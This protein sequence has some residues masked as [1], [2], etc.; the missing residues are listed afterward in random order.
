MKLELERPKFLKAWQTA[1]KYIASKTTIGAMNGIRITAA[2]NSITLEATDMKSSV[3][4]TINEANVQEAGTAVLNA[5]VCGDMLRKTSEQS[6]TLEV[7]DDKGTLK[8]GKNRSRFP[9]IPADTFPNLPESSGAE[10]ICEIMASDLGK[11][12]TEGSCAA[13]APSD[14]PKYMGTCLLRTSGQYLTAVSTDGKRLARSQRLCTVHKEG[15]FLIPAPAL[16]EAAKNFNSSDMVKMFADGSTVWFIFDRKV[17]I[18]EETKDESSGDTNAAAVNWKENVV[19]VLE[20]SIQ[21]IDA[22]FPKFER[23]LNNEIRTT[24]KVSKSSLVSAV[25]R[26]DIIAKNTTAHLMAVL[27]NPEEAPKLRITARAPELGT[28]SEVVDASV[29]GQAMQIGFN[30]AYFLDGLKAADAD[31]VVVEFSD[32]EGQARIFRDESED[33]LY[34]LMPIKLTP[35]DIVNDDDSGD[36]AAPVY[37]DDFS[38]ENDSDSQDDYNP[39]DEDTSQYDNSDAPF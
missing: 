1:E 13:S 31:S 27:M 15:D 17:L 37:P 26:V 8:S 23:I 18:K 33:F 36:F 5:A 39:Q 32:E 12:I 6:I 24:L 16:K 29:D 38:Q 7:R 2:D 3:K 20:F 9:L 21:R 14:F 10:E 30:A 34:M 35:Q 19:E 4:F 11:L 22:S 25:E 28:A